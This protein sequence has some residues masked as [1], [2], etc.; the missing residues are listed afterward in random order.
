MLAKMSL[1]MND[2]ST[3]EDG[4]TEMVHLRESGDYSSPDLRA[5]DEH[6]VDEDDNFSEPVDYDGRS[7]WTRI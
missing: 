2:E 1:V 7:R 4:K 5:G 3:V 6:F